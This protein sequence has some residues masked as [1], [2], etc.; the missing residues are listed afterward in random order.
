MA[1]PVDG[2]KILIETYKHSFPDFKRT[3]SNIKALRL[4]SLD[5][6]YF[7]DLL[8]QPPKDTFSK[9]YNVA[10][11]PIFYVTKLKKI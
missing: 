3:I 10:N 2:T 9:L 1:L 7:K 5:E 8:W 4:V 6:Y 11:P